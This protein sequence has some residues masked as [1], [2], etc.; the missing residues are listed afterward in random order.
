MSLQKSIIYTIA[1]TIGI[2]ND[3]ISDEIAQSLASDAEYRIREI[4]QD[5]AKFMKH[6]KRNV[7]KCEDVNHALSMKNVQPLYGYKSSNYSNAP[8]FHLVERTQDLYFLEDKEIELK[9]DSLQVELPKVPLGTVIH[10]HWLAIQGI[11]PKI[12]Q[13]PSVVPSSET[14]QKKG[15]FSAAEEEEESYQ[16]APGKNILFPSDHVQVKQLVKHVLSSELILYY[17]KAT[18][19]IKSTEKGSKLLL[20]A[21]YKSLSEDPGLGNL[22]PYL[23]RF[24]S[25]ECTHNLINLPLLERLIRAI[26]CLL[27]NPNIH[28][29]LYLHQIMPILLTCLVGKKLCKSPRENHWKLRDFS[30]SI[31]AYICSKYGAIYHTLQPR[32]TKTL[33]HA[34]LDPLRART[35]HYGAIVGIGAMGPS[36]TQLLLLEPVQNSNVA[37]FYRLLEPD[38]R[39]NDHMTQ[40]EA[41]MCFGA[42]LEACSSFFI[43]LSRLFSPIYNEAIRSA[44]DNVPTTRKVSFYEQDLEDNRMQDETAAERLQQDENLPESDQYKISELTRD[45]RERMN[46]IAIPSDINL[47]YQELY[48]IFGEAI[49]PYISYDILSLI[50]EASS[51]VL[52]VDES[53]TPTTQSNMTG[54]ESILL[55][56][57]FL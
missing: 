38:L 7:L 51:S 2:S 19:A 42:L 8:Q 55:K 45:L 1:N 40:F 21:T 9:K 37:A 54:Y 5:A 18:E 49:L 26:Q 44:R 53:L 27:I 4:I 22:V 14:I 12:P 20:D 47:R 30:A 34:F 16:T 23:I 52:L 28:I 46:A 39:S 24:I 41:Q 43:R 31:I 6:S 57:I 13:N 29:E 3:E 36:V 10:S 15:A 50:K 25:E 11:Q 48:S 35:T 32:I 56:D 33:L 17:E